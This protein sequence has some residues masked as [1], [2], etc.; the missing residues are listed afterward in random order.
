MS[1]IDWRGI[2]LAINQLAQI[3][4]P[5]KMDLLEREEQIRASREKKDRAFD[6]A[7]FKFETMYQEHRDLEEQIAN[8]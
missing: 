1:D 7:K 6:T 8:N 4:E 5:S 3:A 2:A